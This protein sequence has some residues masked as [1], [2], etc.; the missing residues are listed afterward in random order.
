MN[1]IQILFLDKSQFFI[2]FIKFFFY[3]WMITC[4]FVVLRPASGL[5]VPD[6]ERGENGAE[7]SLTGEP[8]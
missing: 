8:V 2:N 1:G 3:L 6:S 4:P 5:I 7:G